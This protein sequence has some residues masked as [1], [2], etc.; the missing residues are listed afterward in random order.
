MKSAGFTYMTTQ[1]GTALLKGD[2]AAYKGCIIG[3]STLKKMDLVST[4][5]VIFPEQDTWAG[6]YGNYIFLK[7]MLINKYGKPANESERFDSY[8]EPRDDNSRMHEL[9]MDRILYP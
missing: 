9:K 3:V 7:D 4:I 8:S 2:F 6:L 5:G 1:D